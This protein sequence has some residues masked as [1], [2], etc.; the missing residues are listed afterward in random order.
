DLCRRLKGARTFSSGGKLL[1]GGFPMSKGEQTRQAIIAK[2]APL[3][4]QRGFAGCSMADIMAAAGLEKGG[5]YRHFGSKEE[6]AAEPFRYAMQTALD[7]RS[8]DDRPELDAIAKLRLM[9]QRFVM[10]PS[11]L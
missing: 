2:A 6:L 7:A 10:V 9:V 5:A 3:F 11:P 8:I 1:D 4:N